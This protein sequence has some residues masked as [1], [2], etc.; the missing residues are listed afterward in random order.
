MIGAS[1]SGV[2][3]LSVP[4]WVGA[5]SFGYMQMVLGYFI[6][7][8]VISYVLLPVYYKMNL[9]SIYGY[10]EERYGESAR[11]TGSVYFLLSRVIGASF[12]LYLV[13]LVLQIAVFDKL[14]V[15]FWQTVI[16]TIALIWVYTYKG[17]IRTIV[18]TDTLQTTFL[19]LAAIISVFWLADE[20]IPEGESLIGFVSNNPMSKVWFMDDPSSPQ[21]FLRQFLSGA[22]I[23]IVMTGLD[24]DMMQKNLSCPSLKDAQKNMLWFSLILIGVNLL[25]LSLG[26]LLYEYAEVKAIDASGDKLFPTIILD[27]SGSA[28][29]IGVFLIGL[30]AAAY[31][32]ADS[33]LTA[34]TTSFCVDILGR[35]GDV[36]KSTRML[37][38]VGFSLLLIVVVVVF[39]YAINDPHVISN[40]FK[41]A[42]YTYGPLL[43]LFA[44]GLIT[45]NRI[46]VPWFIPVVSVI[47]PVAT[48]L[49]NMLLSSKFDFQLG[50]EVLALNGLIMIVLLYIGKTP[51]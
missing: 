17:G 27:Y 42:G 10:L 44:Y 48:W 11:T 2:T 41:A 3:F 26:L 35:K 14:G 32:S 50:F 20:L 9:T 22:L 33:A 15:Q 24:Q 31:S 40:L 47:A 39:K 7:Y 25:F 36:S 28:L 38:H 34:L 6:G 13:A 29:L 51:K 5:S 37:V 19:I 8:L 49:I 4:G 16:V 1:L 43:G 18:W 46:E 12:R 45:K 23:T 21:F 30:I